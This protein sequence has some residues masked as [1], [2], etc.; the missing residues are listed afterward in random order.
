MPN[1]TDTTYLF[2]NCRNL[3]SA[4]INTVNVINAH[5]MFNNCNLATYPQMDLSH[6]RNLSELFHSCNNLSGDS[7]I[8]NISNATNISGMYWSV[9]KLY[10]M[11]NLDYSNVVDASYLFDYTSL[12]RVYNADFSNCESMAYMFASC[13]NID[14]NYLSNAH[15]NTT[16]LTN[17]AYLFYNT[18][19][20]SHP[21]SLSNFIY[22]LDLS[23]V[24]NAAYALSSCYIQWISTKYQNTSSLQDIRGLFRNTVIG[25][26][27]SVNWDFSN[28]IYADYAF[29]GNHFNVRKDWNFINVRNASYM[30]YSV[31]SL[32]NRSGF[33]FPSEWNFSNVTIA[34]SMF[35]GCISATNFPAWN[36][37]NCEMMAYMF[38]NCTN[39]KVSPQL[40]T[41]NKLRSC[42]LMFANCVNMTTFSNINTGGV[43]NLVRMFN[44]C[45]KL[46]SV[47][48]IDTSSVIWLNYVFFNCSSLVNAPNWNLSSITSASG[49]FQGCT[50]LVNVPVYN[51]PECVT[52]YNTFNGCNKLSTSSLDNILKTC[53]NAT[54][55]TVKTLKNTVL[56]GTNYT[57][58]TIQSLPSYQD[59]INAGWTIN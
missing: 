58:A 30:F 49:M 3:V 40:V 41:S 25:T 7:P 27:N 47:A 46:T 23:H 37:S 22:N 17:I 56:S 29:A 2:H 51:L 48:N 4:N 43:E 24:T 21:V 33:W 32:G 42:G 1:A 34:L 50:N 38:N 52:M 5:S 26:T 19:N 36:F 12:N 8:Y 39:L 9:R 55:I 35:E 14:Q 16:K 54:N 53:I 57:D 10:N 6:A 15:F 13:Q 11:P 20:T 18:G 45:V 44:S 59:F 31:R 28:V